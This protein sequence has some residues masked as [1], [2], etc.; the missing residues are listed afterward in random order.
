MPN[1]EGKKMSKKDYQAIAAALYRE[2]HG[3][4]DAQMLLWHSIVR[5]MSDILAAGNPRFDR[6]RFALA[7]TTGRCKGMR[8]VAA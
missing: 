2:G 7:C 4:T 3:R 6:E 8:P 1:L 5:S